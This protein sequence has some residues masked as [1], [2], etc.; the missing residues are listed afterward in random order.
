MLDS[1]KLSARTF[2]LGCGIYDAGDPE[3]CCLKLFV[4]DGGRVMPLRCIT[5]EDL[6]EAY[7]WGYMEAREEHGFTYAPGF[8]DVPPPEGDEPDVESEYADDYEVWEDTNNT[9]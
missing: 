6:M 9:Y 8:E 1:L 3:K 5:E 7:S 2:K 4:T